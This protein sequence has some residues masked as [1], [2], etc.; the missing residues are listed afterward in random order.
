MW[1]WILALL[2][3]VAF[4]L[5][6]FLFIERTAGNSI[7]LY[8]GD[9]MFAKINNWQCPICFCKGYFEH[10]DWSGSVIKKYV[11]QGC[12]ACF[13]DVKKFNLKTIHDKKI[14]ESYNVV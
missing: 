7:S 10:R 4:S 5:V 11:C 2:I 9:M 12:S 3:G 13:M 1:T 8:R 14:G 6:W